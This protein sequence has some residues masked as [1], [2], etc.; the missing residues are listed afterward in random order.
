MTCNCMYFISIHTH[1]YELIV[2][3]I[4]SQLLLNYTP[5]HIHVHTSIVCDGEGYMLLEHK[6]VCEK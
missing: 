5:V 4:N 2:N 3:L 6:E 1:T